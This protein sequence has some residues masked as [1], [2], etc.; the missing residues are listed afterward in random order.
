MGSI[1]LHVGHNQSVVITLGNQIPPVSEL[2]QKLEWVRNRIAVLDKIEVKL[3]EMRF[4]A[5]VAQEPGFSEAQRRDLTMKVQ[6]LGNQVRRMDQQSQ[7]N[8]R[9][10]PNPENTNGTFFQ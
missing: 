10:I 3:K 6:M 8:R 1:D 4:L 2:Q 7:L 9:S 5:E